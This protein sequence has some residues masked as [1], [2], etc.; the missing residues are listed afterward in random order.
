[1]G[2][3][4]ILRHAK[5]DSFSKKGRKQKSFTFIAALPL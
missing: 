5:L 4:R 2:T 3:G 1:M